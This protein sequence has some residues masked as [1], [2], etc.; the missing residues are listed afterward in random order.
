MS[1]SSPTGTL[2]VN[3]YPGSEIRVLDQDF[4]LKGR[5][6]VLLRVDLVPGLYIVNWKTAEVTQKDVV[7]VHEGRERIVDAPAP[8]AA[9][10]TELPPEQEAT[11]SDALRPSEIHRG[12]DVVVL[13]DG[14]RVSAPGDLGIRLYAADASG[15]AMRSDRQ[16]VRNEIGRAHV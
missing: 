14:R 15:T 5:G 11:F 13:L 6:T 12:A 10:L 4:N 1:A 7:R 16:A 9:P 2:I 8:P 3:G